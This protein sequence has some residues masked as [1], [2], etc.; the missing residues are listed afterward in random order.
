[1][2]FKDIQRIRLLSQQ[3]ESTEFTKPKE[4]VSWMV[5]IQAQD[6]NMAKWTIGSRLK[7]STDTLIQDAIDKG[8][9]LRT[10]VLRPT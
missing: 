8:E 3:I 10:Y 9:V 1:M 2:L 7:S 4:I 5:A 6:Y